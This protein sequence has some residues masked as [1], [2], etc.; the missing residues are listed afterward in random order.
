MKLFKKTNIFFLLA[1]C[2]LLLAG[3]SQKKN[4]FTSRNF[5]SLAAH[6][7]GL[8]WA[9]VNLD[10]AKTNIEKAQKDDYSKILHVFKYGDEKI[11]KANFPQ[12]DKAIQKTNKVIQYH[13]MLIKGHEYCRWIDHN[14]MTMGMSHFYKRDYYA[15]LL[16]FDYVVKMF[17][18]KPTRYDA[19][20]WIVRTNNQMNSVI[21]TGPI[22]DLLKHDTK[23]PN[24]LRGEYFAVLSDYYLRTEEYKKAIDALNKAIP[25]AKKKKDRA[26]FIY[27]LAQLY[28]QDGNLKKAC[29]LYGDCANLHPPTYEL[30]FNSRLSKARTFQVDNG[31]DTK[32][33]KNELNKMLKDGKNKDYRDQIYYALGDISAR[34]NDIPTALKLFKSSARSSMGNAQQK[35]LSYLRIAD[36]YFDQRKYKFAG[37]YYD[38][39]M[40]FLA[41][42]YKNY[43][44][45]KNKKESLSSLVKNINIIDREDSLLKVA[46]MDTADLS[47]LLDGLIAQAIDDEKKKKEELELK[48]SQAKPNSSADN[49]NAA[50][51]AGAWYFYNQATKNSGFTD[52]FKKWGN[53]PIED[54]WR[55][56]NKQSVMVDQ[57]EA[58]DT[59]T[60]ATVKKD[61]AGASK[62]IPPN[63]TADYYRKNIPF[64]DEQKAKA[65]D[66]ILEAYYNL[67]SIYKEDLNDNE[68]AAETFEDL[69]KHYP[70]SKY[71]LNLYYLLYRLYLANKE[72]SK[73]NFYKNKILNEYPES[74]YAK[75]I[76]N[77]DYQR[78]LQASQNEIEKFYSE[79]YSAYSG[80]KYDEVIAMVGKA[81]SFYSGS[82]LMPKFALLRAFSIGKT[83]GANDY[84]HALQGVIAKYPKDPA[85]AKAQELID[86]IK[87]LQK[88]PVDSAALKKDTAAIYKSP[89]TFKDSSEHQCMI[90]VSAK[91]VNINDFM[92]K[93][94]NFNNEYY[95]LS[96]LTISNLLLDMDHQ[97]F[98]VKKFPLSG[99]AKDYYDFINQ[100]S[101][102]FKGLSTKDYQIFPISTENFATFYKDKKEKKIDEYRNFFLDHYFKKKED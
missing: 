67:G 79:T 22:L 55:R 102:V 1:S 17:S 44:Q 84:E 87:Q 31:A 42:D 33:L 73:A 54:N 66:K 90:I 63:Q 4:T 80:G 24:R 23:M 48:K 46:K 75:I 64:T 88:A 74:E 36:I 49:P 40:T 28:E 50:P 16:V 35:A 71:T 93:I 14:Y 82:K 68:K 53:R 6:Y 19:F 2:F 20:L 78:Q 56:S 70:D 43:E 38:S 97:L 39:T 100:D 89:Y 32:D 72:Q 57:T 37:S 99:K 95:R 58:V 94:T 25:F 29:K 101:V 69:L 34:E 11:A 3:C 51:N 21:K 9:N 77:P 86:H 81:D 13:S 26:R 8:Y 27:I 52:F 7:N 30:E 85:K 91:Q 59:T 15:A 61:T 60:A 65:N 62:K 41:K 47:K 92:V 12:L 5:N 45:I 98:M 76:N 83:K 10:E 18:E 96:D